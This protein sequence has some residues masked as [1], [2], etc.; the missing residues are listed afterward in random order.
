MTHNL[1][2]VSWPEHSTDCHCWIILRPIFQRGVQRYL[3]LPSSGRHFS[4]QI[5]IIFCSLRLCYQP[6]ESGQ[7]STAHG[8]KT[9]SNTP[10]PQFT[11]IWKCYQLSKFPKPPDLVFFLAGSA[12]NSSSSAT[13]FPVLESVPAF[14]YLP[15]PPDDSF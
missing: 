11:K 5:A 13:Y 4:L 15:T 3:I 8:P 14:R 1:I 7:G 10:G 2:V 12:P 9:R 6:L